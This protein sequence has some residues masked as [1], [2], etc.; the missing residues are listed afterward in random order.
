MQALSFK[1]YGL[2]PLE[3]LPLNFYGNASKRVMVLY[4]SNFSLSMREEMQLPYVSLLEFE[5]A[6]FLKLEKRM[7]GA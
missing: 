4:F 7:Q 5:S 6:S 1:S 3:I 2:F